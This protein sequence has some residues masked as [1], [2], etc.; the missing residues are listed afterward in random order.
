[1]MALAEFDGFAQALTD[2]GVAVVIV[3]DAAPPYRPDAVFPNNWVSLLHDGTLVLY[4]MC[5]PNRRTERRADLISMLHT[6]FRITRTIDLS[7]YETEGKFLE[8]TGS[9]VFDHG[10]RM[11]YACSSPRTHKELFHTLVAYLGYTPKWFHATDTAGKAIYHTN[12]MM[13]IGAQF[14]V[15][16]DDAITDPEERTTVMESL[17]QSG[18]QIVSISL[19]QMSCFAG[20]M[21]QLSTTAGRQLLV[22]SQ[23]AY[24]CLNENQL[25]ILSA[26]ATLLPLSIP[27]IEA[28]GGGSAR[29]M[30]AELFAQPV[31][32][33]N[34]KSL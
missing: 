8:G 27:I 20:N 16:C 9:I 21:L 19:Y 23:T 11:A 3:E 10:G 1:M 4:P 22:L 29:C 18:K 7:A 30:I 33:P 28:V 6:K 34:A 26:H 17:K 5:A 31:P 24:D 13:C 25:N 14:A 32:A 2:A 15:I 12:V